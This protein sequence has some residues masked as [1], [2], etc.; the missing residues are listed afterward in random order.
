MQRKRSDDIRNL[1]ILRNKRVKE[2]EARKRR[3]ELRQLERKR[4]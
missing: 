2:F 3:R 4:G 1:L